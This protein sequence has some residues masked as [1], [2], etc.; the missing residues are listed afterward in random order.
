MTKTNPGNYTVRDSKV[1]PRVAYAR[2]LWLESRWARI[3]GFPEICDKLERKAKQYMKN[4][5]WTKA[6]RIKAGVYG[7]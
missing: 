5:R 1:S 4:A 3:M 2:K 7:Q 6:E